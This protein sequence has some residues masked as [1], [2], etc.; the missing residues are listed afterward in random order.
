[1]QA[2]GLQRMLG[3]TL[4]EV[5]SDLTCL[6]DFALA[7]FCADQVFFDAEILT[8]ESLNLLDAERYARI[9]N[10]IA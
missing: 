3:Q 4:T 10:Q 9:C 8:N 7:G 6:N 2:Y 1:M 5:H